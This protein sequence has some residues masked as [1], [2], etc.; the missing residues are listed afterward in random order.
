MKTLLTAATVV[1]FMAS[2]I[3][4]DEV[5]HY[6]ALPSDTLEQALTNFSTY[7]AR[8]AEV[9]ARADLDVNDMEEIHQLTYT[10]E[11]A[12]AKITEVSEELAVTLEEVHLSSEGDN[13]ARL[14]GVAEVYLDRAQVLVP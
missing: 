11:V 14:R 13:P 2:P 3:T 9:L 4:A 1:L 12:L 10:I 7:N 6:E 5:D 8:M